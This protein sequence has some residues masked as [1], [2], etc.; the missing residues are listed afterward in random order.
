MSDKMKDKEELEEE[1][2]EKKKEFLE[3]INELAKEFYQDT[4]KLFEDNEVLKDWTGIQKPLEHYFG[5]LWYRLAVV[6]YNQHW[7]YGAFESMTWEVIT[8]YLKKY[9]LKSEKVIK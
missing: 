4:R 7:D 6:F 2:L 8:A 9:R 3:E 1:L 5:S